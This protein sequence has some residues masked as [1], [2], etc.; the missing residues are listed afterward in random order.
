[1]RPQNTSAIETLQKG[2]ISHSP[3]ASV[4]G[5]SYGGSPT[6][7]AW[8]DIYKEDASSSDVWSL[9][10]VTVDSRTATDLFKEYVLMTQYID[11]V[12]IGSQF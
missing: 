6:T 8:I 11:H 2:P 9:D 10:H 5:S 1:M 7:T 12:L 3:E 4:C